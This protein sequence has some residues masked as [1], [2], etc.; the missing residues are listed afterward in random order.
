MMSKGVIQ[1]LEA[2]IAILMVLV[3]FAVL[4][5]SK[6]IMPDSETAAWKLRGFNSLKSLDESGKLREF[7]MKNDTQSIKEGLQSLLQPNIN[8]DVVVCASGCSVPTIE[9]EKIVST[10]YL[11]S[12]NFSAFEPRQI[13]LYMW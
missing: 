7:A 3:I 12:G 11:I 6:Q 4:F 5:A 8:Y 10:S 13:V 2:V 1:S 9:A